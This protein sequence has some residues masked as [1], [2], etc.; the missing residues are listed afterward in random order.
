MSATRG[1]QNNYLP[2][3]FAYLPGAWRIRTLRR[4]DSAANCLGCVGTPQ[5]CPKSPSAS[6]LQVSESTTSENSPLGIV[7][8]IVGGWVVG[9]LA[10]AVVA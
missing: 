10:S 4:R 7:G 6:A 2:H 3:V 9:L 1:S 5:S 8:G